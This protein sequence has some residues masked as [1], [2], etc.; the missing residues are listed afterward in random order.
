M[1]DAIRKRTGYTPI[2]KRKG[3]V[4]AFEP[5]DMIAWLQRRTITDA[6]RHNEPCDFLGVLF[7]AART[8]PNSWEI[9]D[10]TKAREIW[11]KLLR[12]GSAGV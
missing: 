2:F 11:M 12:E 9:Q 4:A 8:L 3:E 7:E 10:W 1:M 6:Q 5:C